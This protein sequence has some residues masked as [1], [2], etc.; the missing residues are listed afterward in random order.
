MSIQFKLILTIIV[1]IIN[2]SSFAGLTAFPKR[3]ELSNHQKNSVLTLTNND[4]KTT[5]YRIQLVD[6][7]HDDKGNIQ[8]I[9]TDKLPTG[10]LSAKKIVRYSPRQVTIRPGESQAIRLLVRR[11]RS[12]PEG[13]YRSFILFRALPNESSQNSIQNLSNSDDDSSLKIKPI[14]SQ[15]LA[16]PILV[17]QG[18]LSASAQVKSLTLDQEDKQHPQI[19]FQLG[20]TGNR[21]LYGEVIVEQNNETV[22]LA[23]GLTLYNP[24]P[25]RTFTVALDAKKLQS[26]K[27]LIVTYRGLDRD[28]GTTFATGEIIVP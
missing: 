9:P 24:Y 6:Y 21:S 20:R 22:G 19:K 8:V 7:L 11:N 14:V 4:N 13:E 27:K 17:H 18:K 16:L 15:N 28:T 3:I 12:L 1:I 23:K 26:G 2:T 5:K 25:E 10:Y